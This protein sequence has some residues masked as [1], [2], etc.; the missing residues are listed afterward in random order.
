MAML[1]LVVRAR[2]G[3]SSGRRMRMMP[4][5]PEKRVCKQNR[6]GE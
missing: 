5:A 3:N 2:L 6:G 4:A 1:V